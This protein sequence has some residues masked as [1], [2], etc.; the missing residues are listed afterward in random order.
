[1]DAGPR[2]PE[3]L[4]GWE[5]FPWEWVRDTA[6]RV[7]AE[8]GVSPGAVR[9]SVTVLDVEGVWWRRVAPGQALCSAAATEDPL[10][11]TRV[12]REVFES[13]LR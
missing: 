8:H 1:V 2:T 6:E 13:G 12:L 7:A 3:R 11:A 9:G 5:L 10:M 4:R